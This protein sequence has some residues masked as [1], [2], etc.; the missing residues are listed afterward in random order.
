MRR[1]RSKVKTLLLK[2]CALPKFQVIE[3]PNARDQITFDGFHSFL[4][5]AQTK[6]SIYVRLMRNRNPEIRIADDQ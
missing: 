3:G 4:M 6:L 1:Q 5:E 2:I